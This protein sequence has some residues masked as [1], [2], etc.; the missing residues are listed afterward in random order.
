MGRE[1]K[2]DERTKGEKGEE[3]REA[4]EG[5]REGGGKEQNRVWKANE[6]KGRGVKRDRDAWGAWEKG[7]KRL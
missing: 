2:E 6:G 4:R 5:G 1:G 7:K 3:K